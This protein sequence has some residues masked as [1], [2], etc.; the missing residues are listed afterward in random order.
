LPRILYAVS[1][2]GLGHATRAVA[3]GG[4]LAESGADVVFASGSAAAECLRSCGFHVE[5]AVSEPMLTVDNGEMKN[6]VSWYFR[7]WNG[8]RQT[9]KRIGTIVES[10]KPDVVVGD[11]EF[12]S[13]AL[14]LDRGIPHALI[15]DELELGFARTWLARRVERRVSRWYSDLQRRVSLLIIPEEGTTTGNRRYVGP[16]VRQA[17]RTRSQIFEEL[18]IP[19]A[20]RIIL[21]SLSGT[22]IGSHLIKGAIE[23]LSSVPDSVLWL[24]GNRGRKVTGE[25][26]F[27]LGVVQDGQNFVAAA[28][29]VVSTAGK[30]TIDEAAAFGTPIVSI[31]IR[32][33]SEQVRNASALGYSADDLSRLPELIASKIGRRREPVTPKGARNAAELIGS[34]SPS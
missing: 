17:T 24:I 3:V 31:P 7:Y 19:Q 25:R 27:D 14:A 30:S 20:S 2:I 12:S 29:V 23:A 10:W 13:V 18:G 11:E 5:D 22:G 21:V 34:L 8:Y 4:L 32:N 28:D 15:A 6:V 33:H 9:K 26:T 16:I 1:P